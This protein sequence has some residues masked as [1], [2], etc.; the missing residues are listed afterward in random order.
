VKG[1]IGRDLLF[2]PGNIRCYSVSPRAFGLGQLMKRYPIFSSRVARVSRRVGAI[3]LPVCLL[4]ILAHR[5]GVIEPGE[6]LLTILMA[7]LLGLFSVALAVI[8][9]I[10]LWTRGG[11]GVSSAVLGLVYGSAAF[12]PP[13]VLVLVPI[14]QQSAADVSTNPADPPRLERARVEAETT[15][16]F[17]SAFYETSR[18]QAPSDIV[19]RRYRIEPAEL[20]HAA[21]KAAARNGWDVVSETPPD[22]L[23]APTRFQAEVKTPILGLVEDVVVRIRPDRVGALFDMRS[24]SR[25]ALQDI[26]SNAER[27]R[28]FYTDMDDVLLETYGEIESLTVLEEDADLEDSLPEDISGPAN[29][30]GDTVPVPGF[31]PYFE[32]TEDGAPAE[33]AEN[34]GL[35]G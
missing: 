17:L 30:A 28:D 9:F 2:L 26:G 34:A 16:P 3:A 12:V 4:G 25:S 14:V 15:V 6:M 19:S 29:D 18:S 33:P 21:L 7:T 8:A 1:G 11:R 20:H 24:A 13:A 23:D 31:K 22:M 10:Q 35:A 5:S 32:D 27:I